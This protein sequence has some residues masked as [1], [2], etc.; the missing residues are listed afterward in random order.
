MRN[1]ITYKTASQQGAPNNRGGEN[2]EQE[3]YAAH[4]NPE[5]QSVYIGTN[6]EYAQAVEYKD[7]LRH[8]TGKAHFLRDAA[9]QHSQDYKNIMEASLKAEMD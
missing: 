1:S 7:D 5:Q 4:G 9:T 8:T 2:A 3:D 6:V